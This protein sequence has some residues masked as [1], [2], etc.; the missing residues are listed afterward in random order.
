MISSATEEYGY[1]NDDIL[2]DAISGLFSFACNSGAILGPIFVGS[3]IN[4]ISYE[5]IIAS[6]SAGFFAYGFL[7]LIGSELF[8]TWFFKETNS[9]KKL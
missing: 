4:I 5:T 1:T 8:V 7:Y 6:T 3:L 9:S 2:I